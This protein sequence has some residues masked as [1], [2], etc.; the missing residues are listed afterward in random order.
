MSIEF[1]RQLGLAALLLAALSTP[2]CGD[3]EDDADH[4]EGP[5]DLTF[6]GT[7]F[8]PHNGQTLWVAVVATQTNTVLDKQSVTVTDGAFSLSWTGALE[9]DLD[10]AVHYYADHNGSGGCDAPP[11]DHVWSES[12]GKIHADITKTVTH[13]TTFTNVCATFP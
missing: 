3:D 10:Y 11:G 4:D 8:G 12:L 9:H 7:G 6:A 13:S 1:R 2:A 5:F